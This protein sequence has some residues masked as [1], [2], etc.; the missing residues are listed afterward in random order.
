MRLP[1]TGQEPASSA[2]TTSGPVTGH[3]GG[4]G[5][6]LVEL[7]VRLEVGVDK[8]YDAVFVVLLLPHPPS[9]QGALVDGDEQLALTLQGGVDQSREQ[10]VRP[11]R[12]RPQLG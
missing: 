5:R 1:R 8:G 7:A 10:R 4:H 11:G 2:S 3:E 12:A 9:P 6:V